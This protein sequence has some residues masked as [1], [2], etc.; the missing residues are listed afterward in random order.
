MRSKTPGMYTVWPVKTALHWNACELGIICFCWY[1][2]VCLPTASSGTFCDYTLW[3]CWIAL[4]L[5]LMFFSQ[6]NMQGH[7]QSFR[8]T[9][10]HT[11]PYSRTKQHYKQQPQ[12]IQQ[13][14]VNIEIL[15]SQCREGSLSF[16]ILFAG[17]WPVP[18]PNQML[19][20][21]YVV[22]GKKF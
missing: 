8:N 16:F 6:L 13:N 4:H 3:C 7:I 15:N 22:F 17:Y 19:N 20:V 18:N 9:P 2:V 11:L 14:W 10:P 21:H 1:L 12:K 5:F